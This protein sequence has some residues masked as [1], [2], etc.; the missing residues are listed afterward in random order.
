M[1]RETITTPVDL[2]RLKQTGGTAT[3]E[4][5]KHGSY[6]CKGIGRLNRGFIF[7][8]CCPK[9]AEEAEAKKAEYERKRKIADAER[10]SNIPKRYK[11][12]SFDNFGYPTDEQKKAWLA[13]RRFADHFDE[14]SKNGACLL[15]CGEPGTGKT[16]L[17]CAIANELISHG[18]PCHYTG[19]WWAIEQIKQG[20]SDRSQLDMIRKYA[21]YP[22]LIIDEIGRQWG[23]HAEQMLLYQVVNLRYEDVL[24]T[25]AISNLAVGQLVEYMGTAT[26]DRFRENGGKMIVFDWES[27]RKKK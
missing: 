2:K 24:P 13:A 9:C 25:I 18:T 11:A 17:A 15:F 6:R 4:C 26:V 7:P 16:H 22:L 12:S 10:D 23:T 14:M 3:F 21:R 20:F 5:E 8:Q 19:A 27:F 1:D